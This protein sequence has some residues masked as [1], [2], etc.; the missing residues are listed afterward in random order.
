M[1]TTTYIIGYPDHSS[2]RTRAKSGGVKALMES[3]PSPF[4]YLYPHTIFNVYT[5]ILLEVPI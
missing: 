1:K 2:V 4:T 3:Q 5:L